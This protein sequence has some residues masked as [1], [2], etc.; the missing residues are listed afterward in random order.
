MRATK[1]RPPKTAVEVRPTS[2]GHERAEGEVRRTEEGQEGQVRLDDS[3][4]GQWGVGGSF[5][6]RRFLLNQL[7]SFPQYFSEK[8]RLDQTSE[9]PSTSQIDKGFVLRDKGGSSHKGKAA[10]RGIES[11]IDGAAE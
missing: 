1:E 11:L 4:R 8:R 7:N 6:P 5:D 10:A 3:E 9:Y 2:E